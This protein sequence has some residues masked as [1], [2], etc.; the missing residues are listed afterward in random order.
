MNNLVDAESKTPIEIALGIDNE[1]KTTAKKLYDFL[2]LNSS[3]YAR[4]I[5]INILE[6]QFAEENTDYW[7][8]VVN[9]ENPLGGR[10]TQ[11]F[12]LTASFAKKLSMLCKNERGEQARN[13]FIKLEDKLKEIVHTNHSPKSSIDLMELE[14]KAIREV[15]NKI[16]LVD[17]D[18]QHFK[19]DM[20]ILGVEE[21]RITNAVRR[22]GVHCLGGKES[23]AYKD[24]S[25]RGKVYSDI[26]RQLRR[27]FA[28]STYKELKRRQCDLA[29]QIIENYELPLVLREEVAARNNQLNLDIA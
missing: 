27:Q 10:P 20:P 15:E 6:N 7:V 19:Q 22:K 9:D 3:N 13:Y 12:K 1:G 18:L 29:I 16:D 17:E 24:K 21:S 5:K 28:V 4:W 14:L 11:D 25:L 2:E 26:H 23:N 8:F